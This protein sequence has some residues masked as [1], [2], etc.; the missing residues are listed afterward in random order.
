MS[1]SALTLPIV[2]VRERKNER[3]NER[4][5][6]SGACIVFNLRVVTSRALEK[7][8][9]ATTGTTWGRRRRKEGSKVHLSLFFFL[10]LLHSSCSESWK[11]HEMPYC[12]TAI[13]NYA[14]PNWCQN[15]FSLNEFAPMHFL[16]KEM[17]RGQ[18]PSSIP[19]AI[20]GRKSCDFQRKRSF[21]M[22]CREVAVMLRRSCR[23]IGSRAGKER[24]HVVCWRRSGV[25]FWCVCVC[26]CAFNAF[27]YVCVSAVFCWVE[28]RLCTACVTAV[29]SSRPRGKEPRE[30]TGTCARDGRTRVEFTSLVWTSRVCLPLSASSECCLCICLCVLCTLYSWVSKTQAKWRGHL[31]ESAGKSSYFISSHSTVSS[32]NS[33]DWPTWFGQ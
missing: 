12:H 9:Q 7:Q 1:Q 13:V 29:R 2:L 31:Q 26:V 18:I 10:F 14:T 6:W 28:F 19:G 23:E 32:V 5:S 16:V 33:T 17:T 24:K 20:Y 22:S 11:R 15:Y 21:K 30:R 3:K 8:Q 25:V 4:K 27:I